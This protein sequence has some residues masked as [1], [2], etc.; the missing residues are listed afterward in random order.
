VGATSIVYADSSRML[1]YSINLDKNKLISY[2]AS[3]DDVVRLVD[4][5]AN[6]YW[7][8]LGYVYD[9]S[10]ANFNGAVNSKSSAYE[11]KITFKSYDSFCKFHHTT[12]E[13]QKALPNKLDEGFLFTKLIMFDS[14]SSL[15]SVFLN[16]LAN[17]YIDMGIKQSY[18]VLDKYIEYFA[19]SLVLPTERVQ[20]MFDSLTFVV[21]FAF[22]SEYKVCS[23]AD[24][25]T[26][27]IR[28]AGVN[29]DEL[30]YY[31]AH[32][33]KVGLNEE[34]NILIYRRGL[35]KNNV[36]AWYGLA[37]FASIVFGIILWLVFYMQYKRKDSV[38]KNAI[39]S[40]EK[41]DEFDRGKEYDTPK[42]Q[43]NSAQNEQ[44]KASN[45]KENEE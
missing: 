13:E 4:D 28:N 32:S 35:T 9:T 17:Q 41:G 8:Q 6:D 5:C 22:A 2:G 33:W 3:Y 11:I 16:I 27:I 15:D 26:R 39:P 42:T 25:K 14:T 18:T 34:P 19:S 21:T 40:S 1:S 24:F 20:E 29:N 30:T 7:I 36:Y 43:D 31:T 38:V 10:Q 12:I 37:I 44:N 23:N 45:N